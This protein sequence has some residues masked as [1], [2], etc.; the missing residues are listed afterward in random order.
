VRRRSMTGASERVSQS[1]EGRVAA[2]RSRAA[3][4]QY[5]RCESSRSVVF[6]SLRAAAPWARRCS[7]P[8]PRGATRAR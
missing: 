4:S 1:G 5:G 8:T 2:R 3:L 7:S 6:F